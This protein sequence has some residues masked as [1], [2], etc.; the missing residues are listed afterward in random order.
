MQKFAQ[1]LFFCLPNRA[2]LYLYCY[3][4]LTVRYKIPKVA[5]PAQSARKRL[6]FEKDKEVIYYAYCNYGYQLG[7]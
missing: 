5:Y 6:S 4:C 1:T 2:I 3:D 7:R